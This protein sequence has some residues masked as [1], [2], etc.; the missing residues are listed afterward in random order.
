VIPEELPVQCTVSRTATFAVTITP[1]DSSSLSKGFPEELPYILY[2]VTVNCHS[3]S[4]C[5]EGRVARNPPNGNGSRVG[6]VDFD[7][8]FISKL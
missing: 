6:G 2:S 1:V 7:K 5:M 3:G 4:T 8:F